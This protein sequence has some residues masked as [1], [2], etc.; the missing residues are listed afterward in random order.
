VR[1]RY[2]NLKTLYLFFNVPA[3]CFA[4]FDHEFTVDCSGVALECFE[5]D[6]FTILFES[7]QKQ[8]RYFSGRS[9]QTRKVKCQNYPGKLIC[10]DG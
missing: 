5:F 4:K 3:C 6:V 1:D 7:N 9:A 8:T 10:P 2:T